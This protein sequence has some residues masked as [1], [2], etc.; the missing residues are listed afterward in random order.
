VVILACNVLSRSVSVRWKSFQAFVEDFEDS[1]FDLIVSNPP[2]IPSAEVDEL[3]PVVKDHE[4]RG[5]LDG[6]EDGL[7]LIR[8]ILQYAPMLLKHNGE[9]WMEVDRRHPD[10]IRGLMEHYPELDFVAALDDFTG[11]PRFVRMRK[12]M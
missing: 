1:A 7:D 10:M 8:V 2:Y 6:G 12:H 4:D 5:A 3:D 11:Q 9:L